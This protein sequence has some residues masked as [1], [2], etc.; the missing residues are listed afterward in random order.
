MRT[1]MLVNTAAFATT[2]AVAVALSNG[3]AMADEHTFEKVVPAVVG[4][5]TTPHHVPVGEDGRSTQ[6]ATVEERVKKVIADQLEVP[7]DRVVNT[8]SLTEDLGADDLALSEL[9]LAL[10]EEF[11]I[12]IPDEDIDSFTTVQSVIDLVEGKLA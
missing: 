12:R 9:A 4:T 11:G 2:V 5:T 10:E 3:P 1:P 7:E 6:T 8:A